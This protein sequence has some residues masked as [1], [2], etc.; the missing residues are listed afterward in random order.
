MAGPGPAQGELTGRLEGAALIQLNGLPAAAF[1]ALVERVTALVDEP[2]DAVVMPPGNDPAYRMTVFG[3]GYGLVTFY[4]DD[5]VE[6]IR[7]F[8]ITWIG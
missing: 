6:I 4:A 2:R 7:V 8:D 3:S 1:D 5:S